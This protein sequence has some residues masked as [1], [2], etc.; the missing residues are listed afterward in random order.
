MCIRDR[1]GAAAGDG[2]P[3]QPPAASQEPAEAEAPRP[4]TT[5]DIAPSEVVAVPST[6]EGNAFDRLINSWA[7]QKN[8]FGQVRVIML[9]T[10]GLG[11]LVSGTTAY[12]TLRARRK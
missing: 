3:G 12:M 4:D 9:S 10:V 1:A 5:A 6:D 7:T 8:G 11:F 2:G